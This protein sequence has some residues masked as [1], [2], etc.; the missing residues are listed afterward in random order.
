MAHS[1]DAGMN[2]TASSG[3]PVALSIM[4]IMII[5]AAATIVSQI[6]STIITIITI[7]T[8]SKHHQVNLC[9]IATLIRFQCMERL[10][11]SIKSEHA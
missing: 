3:I 8:T 1:Q 2:T 7:M 10:R 5:Q 9:L 4:Q 11:I 6:R